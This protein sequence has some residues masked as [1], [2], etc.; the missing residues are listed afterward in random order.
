MAIAISP[1]VSFH[2]P[3]GREAK[4]DA[5]AVRPRDMLLYREEFS[6][7]VIKGGPQV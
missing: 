6:E 1:F 2:S 4:G 7:A 5:F 3:D